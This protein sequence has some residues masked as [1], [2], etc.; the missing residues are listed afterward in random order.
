MNLNLSQEGNFIYIY[1][2]T[3]FFVFANTS[4]KN[5]QFLASINIIILAKS[6]FNE[7]KSINLK[8][9]SKLFH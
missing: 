7:I 9:F 3:T 4:Y 6:T 5:K 1:T 8:N 2:N